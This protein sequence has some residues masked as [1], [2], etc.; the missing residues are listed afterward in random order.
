MITKLKQTLTPITLAALLELSLGSVALAQGI[1]TATGS[2]VTARSYHTATLLL[3]GKVLVAGGNIGSISTNISASSA[4]LYD[5]AMGAWSTTGSLTT[6]R[7]L[8][9]ATLLPN[10]KV[11]VTGGANGTFT[12]TFASSELYDSATG[13]W[14]TTGSLGTGRFGHTATLLPN[15]KV[16]VTGG[17]SSGYGAAAGVSAELY[18]SATGTWTA[19]GSL[20]TGRYYHTATLLP[21]G[22]ILVTGGNQISGLGSVGIAELYDPA[23]GTWAATG[24]L[25]TARD[26]HTATS[27]PNGKVLVIG[28]DNGSTV[29]GSAELYDPDPAAGYWMVTGSLGTLRS[30]HTATLLPNGKVLVTGGE[31]GGIVNGYWIHLASA[32]LYDPAAGTWTSTGSLVTG[33]DSHTATLLPNG[34]VLVTGGEGGAGNF[35]S[36]ELYD[37]ASP[38][39]FS[40]QPLGE[41]FNA[42]QSFT[43]SAT[44][45]GT[46][47]LSYQW[48]F[49]GTNILGA[50][51]PSLTLTNLMVTNAG[52]YRLVVGNA[53]GYNTSAAAELLYF[54][55]M[56]FLASVVLAGPIGRQLRV[57]YADVVN[58]G[59]TNWHV[60]TNLA[61]PYSPYL[62]IDPNSAGLTKRYYRAVPVP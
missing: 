43:L 31:G 35:A 19:T 45:S 62:V 30:Y 13:L 26:S 53:A 23:T 10:G 5:S 41:S 21:N 47:P 44:V 17:L 39:V 57:D 38:P 36:S 58:A 27:L 18:D 40:A 16:L 60:L 46:P 11:L 33:R 29:F 12:N 51:G 49:N 9:T 4:E 8:H 61:L 32:E 54:G 50:N 3:N 48:Q 55:D 59:T 14:A 56:Q 6:A 15:G 2:L 7:L 22:K 37:S 42:G 20:V 24:S 52:A 34:K 28:G 1:W 25:V